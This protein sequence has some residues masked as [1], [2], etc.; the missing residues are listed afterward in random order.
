MIEDLKVLVNVHLVFQKDLQF[1]DSHL[2]NGVVLF[3]VLAD[4]CIGWKEGADVERC[5][6]VVIGAAVGGP[7]F[8]RDAHAVLV[9]PTDHVASGGHSSDDEGRAAAEVVEADADQL[10]IHTPRA[11]A[12]LPY[13]WHHISQGVCGCA[14]VRGGLVLVWVQ[15]TSLVKDHVRVVIQ[16]GLAVLKLLV[17]VTNGEGL[18]VS[19]S[20][21]FCQLSRHTRAVLLH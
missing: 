14:V 11:N 18:H 1:L 8:F 15:L 10:L 2:D 6:T 3:G 21:C 9:V 5:V 4:G 20:I 19:I 12:E 17:Q 16:D 7:Q 13:L